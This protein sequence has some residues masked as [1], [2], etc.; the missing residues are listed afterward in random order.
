MTVYA[1]QVPHYFDQGAKEWRPKVN[2]HNATPYGAVVSLVP[3]DQVQAALVTQPTLSTLRRKLKDFNDDD[4]LLP[5]GDITLVAMAV[6]VALD[7]N[8]RRVK[9]LRWSRERKAYDV[10]DLNLSGG[11]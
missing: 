10:I 9:L 6:A 2:V 8:R 5:V 4:Y 11:K 7:V 3:H 1:V